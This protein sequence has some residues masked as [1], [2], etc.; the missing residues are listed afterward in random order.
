VWTRVRSAGKRCR[1]GS[2]TTWRSTSC[3]SSS[4]GGAVLR[5]LS[6][7]H[8]MLEDPEVVIQG[9]GVLHLR[10]SGASVTLDVTSDCSHVGT[11][12]SR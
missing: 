3:R 9:D 10:L 1:W 6:N 12:P 4:A 5:T 11:A 7:G 2:S 8:L